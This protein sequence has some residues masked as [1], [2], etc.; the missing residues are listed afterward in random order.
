MFTGTW[1]RARTKE[2]SEARE[3]VVVL[4]KDCAEVGQNPGDVKEE[5]GGE[6]Y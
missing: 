2:F 5:E 6:E 1:A 4:E 3:H